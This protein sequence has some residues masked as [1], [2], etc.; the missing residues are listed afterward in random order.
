M[1]KSLL[2][3]TAIA[4]LGAVA[5]ASPASAKFEVGV[6][7]YME[8]WFGYS[9]NKESV[10]ANSDSFDQVTD[11]EFN[12][13]F[14]QTLDNGLT[15]GGQIQVE[16]QQQAETA[17]SDTDEQFIFMEGSFGRI[18]IG[19]DN[20]AGY[21]MHYGVA[22]HGIGIDEGDWASLWIPGTLTESRATSIGGG[23][24]NDQNKI[25]WFSP[26]VSGLQVGVTYIPEMDVN[27]QAPVAGGTETDAIRDNAYSIA[28]NYNSSFD[29]VSAKFSIAY[30]N[31]GSGVAGKHEGVNAG[32]Q[33]GFGGFTASLA[34]GEE[35]DPTDEVSILGAGL[36]YKAGPAGV[37]IAYI[38]GENSVDNF[39]QN[40]IELGASYAMGPGVTA[41]TSLFYADSK[42][43]GANT[44]N[45]IAAV[46]GLALNF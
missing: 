31:G 27:L 1:K 3:T 46:A 35:D 15:I 25:T 5:V 33:L 12:I 30:Q 22:S 37:S 20:G 4:A 18:E 21:R 6:S 39:K 38:R 36:G 14:K 45:G 7:G 34:Y 42:T 9:D 16:A 24:E 44:A 32:L 10:N 19:T 13:D 29:M 28:A 40:A 43:N 11:A 8:Q 26:R 17:A 41:K 23:I 2:A